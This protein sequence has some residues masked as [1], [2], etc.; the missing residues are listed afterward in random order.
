MDSAGSVPGLRIT[1]AAAPAFQRDQAR[2]R[3]RAAAACAGTGPPS[4]PDARRPAERAADLHRAERAS[5][6]DRT[7]RLASHRRL[8]LQSTSS[9]ASYAP[10]PPARRD[11]FALRLRSIT[12]G[13][14]LYSD[15]AS[16]SYRNLAARRRSA[17]WAR[18]SALDRPCTS[19]TARAS[20]AALAAAD[21]P[22]C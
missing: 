9:F 14:P 7:T 15:T 21:D 13:L 2:P 4:P 22:R 19:A 10:L 11:A 12:V 18:I 16:C 20:T 8:S 17:R 5:T 3:P 6:R 1:P